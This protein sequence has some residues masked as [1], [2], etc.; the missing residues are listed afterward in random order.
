M[1][2]VHHYE[3]K[4]KWELK[5]LKEASF[6]RQDRVL[7]AKYAEFLEARGLNKGRIAKA[8][9]QLRTLRIELKRDF[10]KVDK[11]T[12]EKLVIWINN[13][14]G[15]TA[16]T[17]ADARGWLK[18]FYRWLK[19]G[20]SEGEYPDEVS[21]IKTHVK[22]NE[23]TQ[24]DVLNGDEVEAMISKSDKPRDKAFIA[25]AF[26]GGF[27]IGE[28][29]N[30]RL[31]DVNFDENG[32]RVRVNG[33][34]GPR[35]VRLVTAAPL[36]SNWV[37]QHPVGRARDPNA[38]LWIS[39]A[40]NYQAQERVLEYHSAVKII[41]KA[42]IRAGVKKRIYPHLFRHSS[43]TRDAK[44]LTEAELRIKFGW[45][46]DSDMPSTYVHL[47]GKDVDEKLIRVYTGKPI[48]PAHPEFS[49]ILCS[50]CNEKNT[51]GM[52]FCGKCGTPLNQLEL[53]Q[54]SLE[55]ES[56]K[57]KI[58]EMESLIQ[59]SMSRQSVSSPSQGS[60]VTPL[61]LSGA[62]ES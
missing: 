40:T 26:D 57:L 55:M 9:Y 33:K 32:A 48:N 53:A 62:A 16:W 2:D 39:L 42:A 54:S 61:P 28:M 10:N 22:L 30:I 29:L 41:K 35:V 49:P 59:S 11:K 50:R 24:P 60:Q 5:R 38:P 45:G 14:T 17:K 19:L 56:L 12:I 4:L 21:W 36:L 37:D 23:T 46:R 27:R 6:S 8:V 31:G 1:N 7:L 25:V 15:Y 3:K 20:T 43:A 52:H 13:R 34:T 51:P 58:K 44:Y 47:A 18:R